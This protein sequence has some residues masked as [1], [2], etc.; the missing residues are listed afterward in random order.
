MV[1]I[2][3]M[4][5]TLKLVGVGPT[6]AE[7][8]RWAHSIASAIHLFIKYDVGVDF[9]AAIFRRSTE[10]IAQDGLANAMEEDTMSEKTG[11]K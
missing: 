10:V 7:D 3:A 1:E 5:T 9:Q 2:T 6:N 11:R 4:K 8:C